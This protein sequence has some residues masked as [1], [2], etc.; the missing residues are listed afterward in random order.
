MEGGRIKGSTR[1]NYKEEDPPSSD[2]LATEEDDDGY[3][4]E[5]DVGYTFIIGI[6]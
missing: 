5:E 3:S 4:L 6:S 2:N 1:P